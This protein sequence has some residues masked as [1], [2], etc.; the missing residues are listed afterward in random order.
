[1]V[2]L[3]TR[4]RTL[5]LGTA[6]IAVW[7]LGALTLVGADPVLRDYALYRSSI[8]IILIG[9][10]YRVTVRFPRISV[11]VAEP[12][13]EGYLALVYTCTYI[14]ALILAFTLFRPSPGVFTLFWLW[15]GLVGLPYLYLRSRGYGL[16]SLGITRERLGPAALLGLA[17]AVIQQLPCYLLPEVLKDPTAQAVLGGEIPPLTFLLFPLVLV[18]ALATGPLPE[19]FFFRAVLQTRL[20]AL[21]GSGVAGLLVSSLL[22][23]LWHLPLPSFEL[24][25]QEG[26]L[27]AVSFFVT[28]LPAATVF[29]VLW[30][31]TRHLAAPLVYHTVVVA[32]GGL[33]MIQF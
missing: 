18:F 31:R 30:M 19:E 5:M 7:V 6:L 13:R 26:F 3:R 12:K 2:G 4:P 14:L 24:L 23:G 22:H 25:L 8:G 21:F 33:T 15:G 10:I 17:A 1:M 29:G 9:I 20:A 28:Y 11:S 32:Y 27:V 16:K